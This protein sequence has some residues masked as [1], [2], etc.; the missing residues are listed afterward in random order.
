MGGERADLMHANL[1]DANLTHANLIHADLIHA[2][3]MHAD[4]MHADLRSADLTDANLTDANLRSADLRYANLNVKK[5]PTNSH[6]FIGE[7]LFR[8][9]KNFEERSWAGSIKISTDW[10][11]DD[12]LKNCPKSMI[13]WAKKILCSRWKE[14]E[15]KF[16]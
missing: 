10:C 9:S 6:E 7:V 14:F 13:V 12:F 16:K 8:E 11:W 15:E 2:D 3:L 5:P 1:I 4:L